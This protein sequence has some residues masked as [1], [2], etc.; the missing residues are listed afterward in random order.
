VFE[1]LSNA[2]GAGVRLAQ[3]TRKRLFLH[4]PLEL[5]WHLRC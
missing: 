4:E 3:T 5:T 1:Q 2:Y